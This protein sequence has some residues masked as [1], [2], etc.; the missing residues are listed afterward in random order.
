MKVPTLETPSQGV[1][2]WVIS[3]QFNTFKKFT[4]SKEEME[5]YLGLGYKIFEMSVLS[6]K[7]RNMSRVATSVSKVAAW[8]KDH[9]DSRL[10][11]DLETAATFI[12]R[13]SE[14]SNEID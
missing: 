1:C 7:P 12:H 4:N 5:Q 6:N 3:D 9:I 8:A 11:S 10:I 2:A 14:L 13:S